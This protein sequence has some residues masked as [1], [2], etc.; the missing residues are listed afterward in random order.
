ML[1]VMKTAL[2]KMQISIDQPQSATQSVTAGQSLGQYYVHDSETHMVI[3]NRFPL[4]G[5][6]SSHY[7]KL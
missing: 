6:Y 7:F 4:Y 3:Q 2:V 5:I 1:T